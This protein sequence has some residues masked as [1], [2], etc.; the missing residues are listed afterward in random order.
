MGSDLSVF[1]GANVAALARGFTPLPRAAPALAGVRLSRFESAR[2]IRTIGGY[3]GC[4]LR[5][6][7]AAKNNRLRHHRNP[8]TR[9]ALTAMP[10]LRRSCRRAACCAALALLAGLVT[11]PH[12]RSEPDAAAG[13]RASPVVDQVLR[14]I[15]AVRARGAVCGS[16]GPAA[17]AGALRWSER[18]AS[19]AAAQAD[20][21]AAQQ[22]MSHR[23]GEGRGLS[24]RLAAQGY[25]FGSAVENVAAGH[26][27]VDTVVDAWLVSETHCSNLM[28]PAAV[29]L[30]LACS[31]ASTDGGE[32]R[33]YWDLVLA[34]PLA[35]P[36]A[37]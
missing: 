11:T 5:H 16:A 26:S 35:S 3:I 24:A 10:Q 12:A 33:R 13:C 32:V 21:M 22:K 9:P 18:L 7:G 2:D 23:D 1:G 17:A 4:D 8:P 31:D 25:R 19:V 36:A 15:N 6:F 37:R 30:G 14:R 28:Q 34:A 27:S 20:S 29:E